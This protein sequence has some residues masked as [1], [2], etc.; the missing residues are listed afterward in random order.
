MLNG[1]G[2]YGITLTETEPVPARLRSIHLHSVLA[3][4]HIE[5]P[6]YGLAHTSIVELVGAYAYSEVLA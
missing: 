1:K 6:V 3:H 5:V 2:D 4:H